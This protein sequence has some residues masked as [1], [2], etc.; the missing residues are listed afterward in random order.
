IYA[1]VLLTEIAADQLSV[2]E[3]PTTVS[4]RSANVAVGDLDGDGL[5]ETLFAGLQDNNDTIY[6]FV[7]DTVWDADTHAFVYNFADDFETVPGRGNTNFTPLTFVADF[8]GDGKKEMLIQR[9]LYENF[10][11]TAGSFVRKSDDVYDATNAGALG[12]AWDTIAAVGDIDGDLRDDLVFVSDGF[13]EIYWLGYNQSGQ[14]VLKK[15]VNIF[16]SGAYYP[17]IA[18]GDFDGDSIVV[19]YV[20]SETLFSNPHP[21]ALLAANPVWD[22]VDMQGSTSFGTTLGQEVEREK[23][24]GL[25]VGF[26]IGYES[27]GL[28]GLWSASFKVSVESSFDWTA[29]QSRSIEES[30]TYS[31]S[32]EDKVIFTAIPYDVYYYEIIVSPD[33]E[34]VGTAISVNLPRKPVTLPVERTYYNSHNGGAPDV[35]AS[36]LTHTLG[37]PLSYPTRDEAEVLVALGGGE[38]V[39]STNMLTVGQGTGATAIELS[40]TE[41]NG[42]GTA[43]DF[44]VTIESEVGAGGFTVG[45]SSGF[46]YGESYSI[47]TTNGTVYGGEIGN[48]PAAAWSLDRSFSWGLFSYRATV[49]AEKMVVVQY[50][51]EQI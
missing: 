13:W 9:Y 7:L 8:D 25:S 37:D 50:Y 14:W 11:E 15:N 22:G 36:A 35:D 1:G 34:M 24:V 3:G 38:G 31:T 2:T 39:M 26:S 42:T 43:F 19:R 49:G 16:D 51:T 23:S 45:A 21:I 32:G 33:S 47:M 28:F 17:A 46:H 40:V 41:G 27:E 5:S 10:A 4:L 18:V 20:D 29:T 30:Y 12:A 44:S 48:I 6:A